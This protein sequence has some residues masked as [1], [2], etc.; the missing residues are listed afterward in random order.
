MKARRKKLK[1]VEDVD[2]VAAQVIAVLVRNCVG[3]GAGF[4]VLM[5]AMIVV[6]EMWKTQGLTPGEPAG[7]AA[8][9]EAMVIDP[10]CRS[11]EAFAAYRARARAIH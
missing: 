11:L 6:A 9:A 5:Y 4:A 3:P 7:E 10:I 8:A 1:T 2:A